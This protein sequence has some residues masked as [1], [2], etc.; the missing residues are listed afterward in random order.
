MELITIS[1][2]LFFCFLV[3]KYSENKGFPFARGFFISLLVSPL[4]GAII[5]GF[6]KSK[7]K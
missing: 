1:L 5:I 4:L 6:M 2:Y 3:G 7:G